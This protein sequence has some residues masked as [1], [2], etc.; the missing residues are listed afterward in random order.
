MG[1]AAMARDQ[2]IQFPSEGL[3]FQIAITA[4][5]RSTT[6]ARRALAETSRDPVAAIS[7]A[8]ASIE[9]STR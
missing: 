9:V 5:S 8:G 6:R 4:R 1:T 3:A 7:R 2:G